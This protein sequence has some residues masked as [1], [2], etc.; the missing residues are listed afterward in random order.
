LVL[1]G[2]GFGKVLFQG[3]AQGNKLIDPD[4]NAVPPM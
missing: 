2:L 3:V 4:D 1:D